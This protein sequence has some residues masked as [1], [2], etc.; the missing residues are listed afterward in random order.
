[1]ITL[2]SEDTKIPVN[3]L[4]K[5]LP[6]NWY[7]TYLFKKLPTLE[8]ETNYLGEIG[9]NIILP[10]TEKE[11]S[12][13]NKEEIVQMIN[14]VQEEHQLS[15][16]Y[17]EPKLSK[18]AELPWN[19]KKWIF[20]YL[21]FPQFFEK[22]VTDKGIMCKNMRLIVLDSHDFKAEYILE[23]LLPNLNYLTIVT[24]RP[25]H[26]ERMV[27]EAYCSFGLVIEVVEA[28]L[29]QTLKGDLIIDMNPNDYHSFGYFEKGA[30]IIYMNSGQEK[31][32]YMECRKKDLI[33]I[34]DME[35]K[36]E[37]KNLDKELAAQILCQKYWK[38]LQFSESRGR[39]IDGFESQEI[40]NFFD[41]KVGKLK[42]LASY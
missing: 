17:I 33:L 8:M 9:N 11:L 18:Y 1:M 22:I 29:R 39:F 28:P 14:M 13:Y 41:I 5:K 25:A 35:I 15:Q 2:A 32:L 12:H 40:I 42:V 21:L 4:M 38:I 34:Y 36:R 16:V 37:G 31:L 10:I 6:Y 7:K 3:R 30:V 27:E 23:M 19:T 26:F 20:H 24:E